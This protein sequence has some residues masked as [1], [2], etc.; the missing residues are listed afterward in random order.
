MRDARQRYC[1]R[2]RSVTRSVAYK[3]ISDASFGALPTLSTHVRAQCFRMLK[4]FS[5]CSSL[6]RKYD[7]LPVEETKKSSRPVQLWRN[8]WWVKFF[9]CRAG[10][11]IFRGAGGWFRCTTREDWRK[12]QFSH[13]ASGAALA[14]CAREWGTFRVVLGTKLRHLHPEEMGGGWID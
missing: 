12:M 11:V 2:W 8:R 1:D 6:M 9:V 13:R 5:S 14:A 7:L 4:G 10:L 3:L